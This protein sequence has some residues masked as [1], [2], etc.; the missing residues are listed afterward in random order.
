MK[1]TINF[2]QFCDA[3]RDMDRNENFSYQGKRVLFDWI[4][5]YDESCGTETELDVIALC[6]EFEEMDLAEVADYYDIDVG[7][8]DT[9]DERD[10]AIRHYLHENT[11]VC[12]ETDDGAIVYASF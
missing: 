12:G 11:C 5:E 4:E 3:F 2:S 10:E 8:L 7:D 1:R 6:C 9:D